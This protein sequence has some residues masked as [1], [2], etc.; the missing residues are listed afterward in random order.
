MLPHWHQLC[1]ELL[2]MLGEDRVKCYWVGLGAVGGFE[3]G[4]WEMKSGRWPQGGE[5]S[6]TAR[7]AP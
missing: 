3:A 6:G 2:V 7:A 4:K 1:H 5:M